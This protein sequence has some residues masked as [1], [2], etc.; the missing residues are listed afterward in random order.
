MAKK[1]ATGV[2]ED[3]NTRNTGLDQ[4]NLRRKK[5]DVDVEPEPEAVPAVS[6]GSVEKALDLAFN[7]TREKIRE[8]TIIDRIQ[9]RLFPLLDIINTGRQYCLE[10]AIYR[11]NPDEYKKL[12]KKR[13]PILPNL[14]DD[15]M[16]RTAQWQK[17]VQGTNLTKITDIALAETETRANEEGEGSG[18]VD[19]WGKDD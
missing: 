14:L 9:G 4:D 10:V 11:Q 15:F 18:G 19:M 5:A 16:Y 3:D 12:F 13:R 8:V 6:A 1:V 7:P 17:S 2:P